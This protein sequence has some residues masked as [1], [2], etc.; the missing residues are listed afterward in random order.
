ML[1][2]F[3]TTFQDQAGVIQ[4]VLD[5]LATLPVRPVLTLGPALDDVTFRV[6]ESALVIRQ[7]S[8]EK[9]LPYAA[10]VITH[11]GHGTVMR[12]LSHGVPLLCLPMGRDQ[13]DNA[14]RVEAHGAGLR[15]GAMAQASEIRVAFER[16][17]AEPKF[18]SSAERMGAAVRGWAG[19]RILEDELEGLPSLQVSRSG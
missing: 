19:L 18:R 3:S 17:L 9:I 11:A 8:H 5:A 7:A 16:I 13:A 1:I 4:R 15:L 10:C 6:P 12:A 2:A 14:V